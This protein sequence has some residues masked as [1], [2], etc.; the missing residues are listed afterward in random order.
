MGDVNR[1]EAKGAKGR[2]DKKPETGEIADCG[3]RIA[4]TRS[5]SLWCNGDN[6]GFAGGQSGGAD[7]G[8]IGAGC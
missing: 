5:G 4:I 2:R 6:F 8:K 1:E 3:L 7:T